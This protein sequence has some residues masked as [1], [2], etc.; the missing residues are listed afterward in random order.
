MKDYDGALS[1]YNQ[2]MNLGLSETGLY[3]NRGV[4]LQIKKNYKAAIRD[5]SQA[6]QIDPSNP[7]LFY[8]R[9][10]AKMSL[11]QMEEALKDLEIAARLGY[12]KAEETIHIY[13]K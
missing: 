1:D 4:I 2:A 5:Y 7:K 6:I 12:E 13:F 10:I 8:N 3:F 9:A 11:N